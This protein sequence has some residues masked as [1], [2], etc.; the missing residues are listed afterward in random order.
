MSRM[1]E[2]REFCVKLLRSGRTYVVRG[3]QTVLDGALESGLVLPHSCR[4]G[5]CGAC[6]ARVLEGQV[7]I[8][9]N[10]RSVGTTLLCQAK[11]LTDLVID[12][13]ELVVGAVTPRRMPARVHKIERVA[14]D[15]T[16]LTLRLPEINPLKFAAGQYVDI[17]MRDGG[18]RSYSIATTPG[19]DGVTEIQLHVRQMRGGRFSDQ[20]LSGLKEK[21]ILRIE[22]PFGTFCLRPERSVPAILLAS[23]TGIAPILSIVEASRKRGDS[24]SLFL[25]WG[26]RTQQDLYLSHLQRWVESGWLTRYVPVLSDI[27]ERER[28]SGRTGL[29]HHAV[30]DDFDD[31]SEF[32][33]YA[34][35]APAMVDAARRDFCASRG[36][37]I[38]TFHSDAFIS[39]SKS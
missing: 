13:E 34:C 15:V 39:A 37:S 29:V 18:R 27:A 7:D 10:D 3:D 21:D 24:R 14:P 1:T 38:H 32:E 33:V 19:A 36:L 17:L 16:V 35:G 26:C 11:P 6:E 22:A 23:G 4:N 30:M 31:L 9:E 20:M 2:N 25:Y 28:W 8:Q 5:I 12:A